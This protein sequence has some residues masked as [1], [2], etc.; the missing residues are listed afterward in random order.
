MQTYDYSLLQVFLKKNAEIVSRGNM[1]FFTLS[2]T[3]VKC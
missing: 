2:Y 3:I 1:A